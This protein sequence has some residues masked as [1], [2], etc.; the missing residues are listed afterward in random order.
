M[1]GTIM[2]LQQAI[3]VINK[4]QNVTVSFIPS[5]DNV[6]FITPNGVT[7]S[8]GHGEHHYSN[9]RQIGPHIASV[10]TVEVYVWKSNGDIVKTRKL[11]AEYGQQSD[12]IFGWLGVDRLP[13]L[14]A[15]IA[16]YVR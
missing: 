7:I 11:R 12:G 6:Q 16:R 2:T 1:G 14:V 4:T 13:A 15:H 9:A 3:D 8:V 5:C 10:S